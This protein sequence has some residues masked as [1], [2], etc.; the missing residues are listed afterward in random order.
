MAVTR[1]VGAHGLVFHLF[2]MLLHLFAKSSTWQMERMLKLLQQPKGISQG[3]LG[4]I[5]STWSSLII[6]SFEWKWGSRPRLTG[7]RQC[8]DKLSP[9]L[10]PAKIKWMRCNKI[11]SNFC[12]SVFLEDCWMFPSSTKHLRLDSIPLSLF[13]SLIWG[14]KKIPGS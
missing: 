13:F 14:L 7:I 2:F 11:L 8:S 12:P 9:T 1:T 10:N 6:T 5:W 4:E 3:L